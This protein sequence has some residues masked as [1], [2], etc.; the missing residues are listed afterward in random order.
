MDFNVM[1]AIKEHR[2]IDLVIGAFEGGSNYWITDVR[3][4][5]LNPSTDMPS[6][7]I[8]PFMSTGIAWISALDDDKTYALTR[9]NMMLGLHAMAKKYS[10]HWANFMAGQDDA[11]TSDVFLQCCL[12]GEIVYG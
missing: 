12:F 11:E 4:N 2:V 3:Y 5:R 6:Y 1:Q 7:A 8:I 9:N 10:Q